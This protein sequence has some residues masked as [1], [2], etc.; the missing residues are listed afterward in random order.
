VQKQLERIVAADQRI[1]THLP[2]VLIQGETGTGKTTVARW[3][4]HHGPRAAAPLVEVNCS[5]LPDTLAESELFG[6][7]R[8]A[9]T[10]ARTMRMG[11]FE[12]ANGGTLFLDELPS[13][14]PLLQAKVLK[15]LE[16][17]RIRRLGGNREIPIDVRIVAAGPSDLSGLVASGQFRQDLF[18]RLDLYRLA[19]LPLRDRRDDLIPLAQ[20]LLRRIAR[21]HR[22]PLKPISLLGRERLLAHP[23]PGNVRELGHELE[24]AVVFEEGA[25]LTFDHLNRGGP[26]PPGATADPDEWFN[27]LFSFPAEGFSL[28]AAIN[29]MIQHALNQTGQNVSAAARLLG[30][31]RDYVRY[32][33]SGQKEKTGESGQP[34]GMP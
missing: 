30:V 9:F 27:T 4:H 29:R 24:R 3:L 28:E 21:R 31:S 19:L 11:L 7:E 25:E 26:P 13:L 22:V 6:H 16:D 2:P 32:R 8:G 10:D 1:Q 34:E 33:L 12:A 20:M 5:A 17:H 15:A 23:W 18:H 14:S